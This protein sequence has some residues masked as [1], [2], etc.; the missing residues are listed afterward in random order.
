MYGLLAVALLPCAHVQA[1]S[2][3]SC[4]DSAKAYLMQVEDVENS[5]LVRL[6]DFF[7]VPEFT[8]GIAD[9]RRMGALDSTDELN[10]RVV[11]KSYAEAYCSGAHVED[12]YDESSKSWREEE[13]LATVPR[14]SLLEVMVDV[15]HAVWTARLKSSA[16]YTFF[17]GDVKKAPLMTDD[18]MVALDSPP[19]PPSPPS[20]P[21]PPLLE[22]QATAAPDAKGGA[23]LDFDNFAAYADQKLSERRKPSVEK[24]PATGELVDEKIDDEMQALLKGSSEVSTHTHIWLLSSGAMVL[25]G[26]IVLVRFG[27][28]AK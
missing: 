11:I 26:S 27:F 3:I 22:G 18:E 1:S 21:M 12:G 8:S 14:A 2:F 28:S 4:E 17:K 9:L 15:L 19:A 23:A 24:L 16:L 5:G 6:D 20:P 7:D 10:P 25:A 13:E